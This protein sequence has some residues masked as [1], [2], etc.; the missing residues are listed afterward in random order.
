MKISVIIPSYRPSGY[1]YECLDSLKKQTFSKGQFEIIL[2]LNG[3]REPYYSR[4]QQF[5]ASRLSGFIVRLLYTETAGVSNA[6]NI[7]IEEAHG[8]YLA[9]VDDDDIVSPE[10]LEEMYNIAI[11]GVLP[12]S[13]S[14]AFE[15]DIKTPCDYFVG[16]S[17]KK[18]IGRKIT[19]W[20]ARSYFS[21]VY[22]KL[23]HK[24]L[25]GGTRFNTKLQNREDV[26]FMF[27]ISPN[28]K[29][30]R[31]TAANAVYYVRI[32]PQSLSRKK[33]QFS[34]NVKN[35][36]FQLLAYFT[37]YFRNP[38]KYNFIFFATRVLSCVR[39]FF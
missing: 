24:D 33:R 9:F 17:Y 27:T 4:I 3:E 30:M 25:I 13:Y 21:V 39:I 19:I 35:C 8:E 36:F 18:N 12:L 11:T 1:L 10:Y 5:A 15:N 22:L 28:I 32:R 37:V 23:I 31:L 14:K 6:R 34:K 20:S 2:V 38:F 29:R 26:L 16:K 7:G